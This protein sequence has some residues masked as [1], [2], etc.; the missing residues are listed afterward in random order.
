[1]ADALHLNALRICGMNKKYNNL[2]ILVILTPSKI[3]FW[4]WSSGVY[5]LIQLIIPAMSLL[6]ALRIQQWTKQVKV[7]PP[8]ET[9]F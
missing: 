9:K 1:M 5:S 3:L 7:Y 6:C 8:T 2:S 4:L